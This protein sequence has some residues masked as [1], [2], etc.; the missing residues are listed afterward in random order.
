MG[1]VYEGQLYL[2]LGWDPVEWP[3][4]IP[5]DELAYVEEFCQYLSDELYIATAGGVSL[6]EVLLLP[7]GWTSE[8][9]DVLIATAGAMKSTTQAR[10]FATKSS[11]SPLNSDA[12]AASGEST[13]LTPTA[14]P[15][16]RGR[17]LD[18]VR[19]R[20]VASDGSQ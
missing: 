17:R 9:Q 18:R 14:R 5:A 1:T 8:S 6:A 15:W 16:N 13:R 2:I 11:V 10:M 7:A 12:C 20:I 19:C 3:S 4:A